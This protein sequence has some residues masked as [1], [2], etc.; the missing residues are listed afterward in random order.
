MIKGALVW[1]HPEYAP[2]TDYSIMEWTRIIV[3][4]NPSSHI[5]LRTYAGTCDDD[6]HL[7]KVQA[8]NELA[9]ARFGENYHTWMGKYMCEC[10][11]H[12]Y[13]GTFIDP[14][15]VLNEHDP[16]ELSLIAGKEFKAFS[17]PILFENVVVFGVGGCVD[18]Q[19]ELFAGF[20]GDWEK[21]EATRTG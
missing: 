2:I 12:D 1:V 17:G 19:N 13:R 10:G 8:L 3:S 6:S 20:T 21:Y 18:I 14:S 9:K 7:H 5:F 4:H 11:K 15:G 16:E